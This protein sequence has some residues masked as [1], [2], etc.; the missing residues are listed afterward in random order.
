MTFEWGG[1]SVA[2]T[3]FLRSDLG[4]RGEPCLLGTNVVIPLGLMVPGPGV[5]PWGGD[6]SQT[7]LAH[8][9]VAP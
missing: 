9:G 5:G 2:S 3:V 1:K 4:V 8:S 7:M 6:Q